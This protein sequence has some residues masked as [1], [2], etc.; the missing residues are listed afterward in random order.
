MFADLTDAGDDFD[1]GH[2]F[3]S[4]ES[5]KAVSDACAPVNA[6]RYYQSAN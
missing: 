3:G 6:N 4:V 1:R 5:V 2:S